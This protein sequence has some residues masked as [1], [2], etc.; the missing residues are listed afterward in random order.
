MR[1]WPR[2]RDGLS[3]F[4]NSLSPGVSLPQGLPEAAMPSF[5]R[6]RSIHCSLLGCATPGPRG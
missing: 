2:I 3:R 4:R 1:R 6:V 5:R